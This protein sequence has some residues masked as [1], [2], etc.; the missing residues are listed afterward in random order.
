MASHGPP[1]LWVWIAQFI[2]PGAAYSFL[3]GRVPGTLPDNIVG[4]IWLTILAVSC[5]VMCY[6]LF[7]V[8]G[9]GKSK[10]VKGGPSCKGGNEVSYEEQPAK[11]PEAVYLASRAQANQ[12]EQMPGFICMAFVFSIVVNGKVGGVLSL[13]WCVLRQCYSHTMRGSVGVPMSHKG[14]QKFT[15]PCYMIV[16]SMAAGTSIHM[17]RFGLGF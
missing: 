3:F 17:A 13:I 8:I 6:I 12:V 15:G 7:D 11:P 2:I 16:G 5:F 9:S 14:V 4:E 1:P 10:Y